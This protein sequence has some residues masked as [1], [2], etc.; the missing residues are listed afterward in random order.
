MPSLDKMHPR[1]S[2]F[3]SHAYNAQMCFCLGTCGGCCRNSCSCP[4]RIYRLHLA[5]VSYSTYPLML[6]IA[7]AL[8]W[9][10]DMVYDS[11]FTSCGDLMT[12]VLLGVSQQIL[13]ASMTRR[14][15]HKCDLEIPCF[16]KHTPARLTQVTDALVGRVTPVGTRDSGVP[17][18]FMR[19]SF[20]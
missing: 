10:C 7:G 11:Y 15:Q 1:Y 6:H 14:L 16:R 13:I 12:E 9:S 19:C 20:M 2:L 4:C 3:A 17:S 8:Y 5:W 18:L